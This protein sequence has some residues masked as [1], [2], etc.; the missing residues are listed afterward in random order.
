[1]I[2]IKKLVLVLLI[3]AITS[4]LLIIPAAANNTLA[5]G[6][7]TVDVQ[8]LRL[9]SG[10]GTSHSVITHLSE[11]NIVVVLERTNS[12]WHKVNY[13]GNVGFVSVPLLRDIIT[14]ENFNAQ[15]RITGSRVNVRARPTTSSDVLGTYSVNTSMNV[16]GINDGWY[17]IQ[18]AGNTGYVRSDL[19]EITGSSRAT[20]SGSSSGSN[21]NVASISAPIPAGDL[22]LGQQIADFA[23]SYVGSRYVYGGASPSGFDCSGLVTYVYKNF[24]I[25]VTRNASGQYRDNGVAVPKADMIPGDLVFFSN[26]GRGVTHVGIYIGGEQFVHASRPGVGVVVTNLDSSYYTTGWVGAKRLT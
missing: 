19:M 3:I 23:L 18:H 25:S 6:A 11:G 20:S 16:I 22:T 10:P 9:R 15:G 5:Y 12:E 2:K 14:A 7:A 17:K 21:L 1:M 26:N 24:G 4:T 8:G 13:Q